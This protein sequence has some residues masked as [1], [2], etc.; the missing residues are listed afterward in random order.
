MHERSVHERPLE[1]DVPALGLFV[2][3]PVPLAVERELVRGKSQRQ[4]PIGALR[5][6]IVIRAKA[7]LLDQSHV[8]RTQF[9]QRI[10]GHR[11]LRDRRRMQLRARPLELPLHRSARQLHQHLR[12]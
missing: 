12:R 10:V 9:R 5:C 11:A 4:R 8:Q 7:Q 1:K 6:G 3:N 2:E